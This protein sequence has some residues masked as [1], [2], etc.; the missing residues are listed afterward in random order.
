MHSSSAETI[1]SHVDPQILI[2]LSKNTVFCAKNTVFCAKNTVFCASLAHAHTHT[3]HIH[4][5]YTQRLDSTPILSPVP[6]VSCIFYTHCLPFCLHQVLE[7]TT[8]SPHHG[9]H[10]S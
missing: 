2:E 1:F 7:P 6:A 8:I 10:C 9:S 4:N 5:T 3:Q